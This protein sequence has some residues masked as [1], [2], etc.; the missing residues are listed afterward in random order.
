M[1]A[2]CRV[3][4][5]GLRGRLDFILDRPRVGLLQQAACHRGLEGAAGFWRVWLGVGR[6][7]VDGVLGAG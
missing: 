2:R 7:G 6:T 1:R 5:S 3:S 4:V